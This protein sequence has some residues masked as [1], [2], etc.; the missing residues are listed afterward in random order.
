MRSYVTLFTLS[1]LMALPITPLVRRKATEWRTNGGRHIQAL[2]TPRLGGIAVYIA[3]RA[4]LACVLLESLNVFSLWYFALLALGLY[5]TA[6]LS[7]LQATLVIRLVWAL[8]TGF[9]IGLALGLGAC[10]YP[11]LFT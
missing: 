7:T 8:Q 11:N 6:R 3:F 2:P 1:F 9:I 10:H 4:A 5:L